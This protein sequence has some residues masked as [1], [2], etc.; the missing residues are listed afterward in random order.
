[1]T[2]ANGPM[3]GS[4]THYAQAMVDQRVKMLTAGTV[5]AARL[6]ANVVLLN[7]S[8]SFGTVSATLFSGSGAGLTGIPFTALTGGVTTN[9]PVPGLGNVTNTLVISNGVIIRVQ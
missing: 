9:L 8:P 1:M 7:S 4:G 3:Q 2:C 6:P 5:P